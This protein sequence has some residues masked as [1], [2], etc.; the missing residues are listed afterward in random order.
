MGTL[1]SPTGDGG[2]LV[3]G[4]NSPYDP[5]RPLF[6]NVEVHHMASRGQ[7]LFPVYGRPYVC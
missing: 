6:Q 1:L 7:A 5:E 3:W 4:H 2:G